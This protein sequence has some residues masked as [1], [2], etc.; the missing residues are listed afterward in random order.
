MSP[1]T[2]VWPLGRATMSSKWSEAP[3][4]FKT[5]VMSWRIFVLVCGSSAV[6][7][8]EEIEKTRSK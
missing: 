6:C 7:S 2:H 5:R 8:S 4:G 3:P 1:F